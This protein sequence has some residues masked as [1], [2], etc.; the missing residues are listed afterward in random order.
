MPGSARSSPAQWVQAADG[1]AKVEKVHGLAADLVSG[2]TGVSR[3][4]AELGDISGPCGR[5]SRSLKPSM[6]AAPLPPRDSSRACAAPRTLGAGSPSA[7]FRTAP[8]TG[9]L[10]SAERS[11]P[12][13]IRRTLEF[14][15]RDQ[16]L[17]D[18]QDRAGRGQFE[19]HRRVQ[20]QAVVG[21][22]RT[23]DEQG[24]GR[25]GDGVEPGQGM[26]QFARTW[27]SGSRRAST[28]AGMASSGMAVA[29]IQPADATRRMSA[30]ASLRP[31]DER[32]GRLGRLDH[33]DRSH[34]LLANAHLSGLG[35]MK[36]AAP[37]RR[38][39]AGPSLPSASAA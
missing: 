19:C 21:I 23:F 31:D 11:E 8:A 37:P 28:R 26:A 32:L 18:L 1:L 17:H 10:A 2:T 13:A 20:P 27:T 12:A 38:A 4:D 24:D 33:G 7:S 25:G 9:L 30:Q 16:S 15:S 5:L 6:N 35:G 29:F 14:G 34:G 3:G 36:Q 39:A 22:G